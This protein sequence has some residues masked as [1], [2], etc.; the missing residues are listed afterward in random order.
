MDLQ[1]CYKFD[2]PNES[3]L[4]ASNEPCTFRCDHGETDGQANLRLEFLPRPRVKIDVKCKAGDVAKLLS[5]YPDVGRLLVNGREFPVITTNL[6]LS[7]SSPSGNI[8]LIPKSELIHWVGDGETKVSKVVFHLFNYKDTLGTHRFSKRSGDMLILS[9]KTKLESAEWIVELHNYETT[10]TIKKLRKTG[11]YGLTHI[12]CF[13]QANGALFDAETAKKMLEHLQYFFT[14]SKG[15]LCSPVLPVGFDEN[16]QRVWVLLNSPFEPWSTPL[17]WFDQHHC[18]QLADLFPGIIEKLED[19]DWA[20]TMRKAIYWYA[21]SNDASGSGVETGIILTQI[22]IERLAF[23]YTVNS[24]KMIEAEDFKNKRAS[25]KFRLLF[26]SLGIPIDIPHNPLMVYQVA[27]KLRFED[28]PHALTD[29]RNSLV[30]PDHRHEDEF[31]GTYFDARSLGLWYLELSILRICDYNSTYFNRL[32]D[33]LWVGT[34]EDVPWN[35]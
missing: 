27:T 31:K 6:T 21:Q 25:D 12:G 16:G 10:S 13:Y 15:T 24:K 14:F 17:S 30:H 35:V 28:A 33:K 26:N 20:D 8:T 23:E 9:T 1:P 3:V 5:A 11:G 32:S 34:V 29:I 19:K 22:A 4:L 2:E 18:E 7:S